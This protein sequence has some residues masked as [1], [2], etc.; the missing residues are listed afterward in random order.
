L[1]D[2]AGTGKIGFEQFK[3]A[4]TVNELNFSEPSVASP[5]SGTD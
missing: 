5:S 2:Q 4:A 3:K 1:L